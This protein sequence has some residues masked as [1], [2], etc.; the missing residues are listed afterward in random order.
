MVTRYQMYLKQNI[1]QMKCFFEKPVALEIIVWKIGNRTACIFN[2]FEL[3]LLWYV[4][5]NFLSIHL[6]TDESYM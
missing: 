3:N 1:F 4:L 6:R 2:T 5:F